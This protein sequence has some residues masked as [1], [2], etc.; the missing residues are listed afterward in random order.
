LITPIVVN[1]QD[2]ALGSGLSTG[3]TFYEWRVEGADQTNF[4][5][6]V[7]D[8]DYAEFRFTLSEAANLFLVI[9]GM[10]P[11]GLAAGD[12]EIVAVHSDDGFAT[13]QVLYN[14]G[15]I[16]SATAATGYIV[17]VGDPGAVLL[18]PGVQH[19]L[20]LYYFNETNNVTPDGTITVDDIQ[21]L[22]ALDCQN[23][24]I[25]G[26]GAQ[27]HLDIDSDN[28]GILDVVE[29]IGD[30]DGDGIADFLDAD[31]DND[32]ITDVVEAG[33]VDADGRR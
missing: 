33:G 32:G 26:D 13:S 27:D 15:T 11:S 14:D 24:D 17:H 28:D 30:T 25:D 18:A 6:A 9:Q 7:A 12:Y 29:G 22:F 10:A 19:T 23:T 20:R 8:K 5:D 3:V 21:L 4:A 31:S 1:A 16:G 2:F